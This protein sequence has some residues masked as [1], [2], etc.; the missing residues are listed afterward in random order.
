MAHAKNVIVHR[1]A[2][3]AIDAFSTREKAKIMNAVGL[4]EDTG[5]AEVLRSKSAKLA[6][7]ESIYVMRAAPGIRLI[8][9]TIPN[10]I[11]VLDVVRKDTLH[12]FINS[13][14]RDEIEKTNGLRQ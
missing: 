12:G 9:R 6:I 8:Y 14:I 4:L 13:G 10:G 2:A 11:E 3:M 5:K 1:R 7:P